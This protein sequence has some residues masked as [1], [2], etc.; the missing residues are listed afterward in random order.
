MQG[1]LGGAYLWVLSAHV[2]FVIFWIAGLF[3]LGRYLV[4]QR[5][6][7]PGSE[8]EAL[9][10][11]RTGVLRR[12]ILNPSM[13]LV[14]GLG[15]ALALNLGLAG[16]GWLHAKILIVLLLSGWHGWAVATSKT[17]GRGER[18]YSDKRLRI[19]NEAP[20]FAVIL[21]VILVIVRPF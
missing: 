6:T 8:A 3:A 2:I 16:Q 19:L 17:L 9:W 5:D 14:W 15:L 20:A 11:R 1:W 7:A 4:Y 13:F 12:M 21:V 18:P 10:G